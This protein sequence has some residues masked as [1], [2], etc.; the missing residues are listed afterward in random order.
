MSTLKSDL[1]LGSQSRS[2]DAIA[3]VQMHC[4]ATVNI[5]EKRVITE[6]MMFRGSPV[7][8]LSKTEVHEHMKTPHWTS[9]EKVSCTNVSLTDR[10]IR[11]QHLRV[12]GFGAS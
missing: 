9:C 1:E 7:S 10:S 11:V 5:V 6:Q 3:G 8:R 4:S 2:H 12:F